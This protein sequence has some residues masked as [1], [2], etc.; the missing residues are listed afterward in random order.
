MQSG[1]TLE[2]IILGGWDG[3]PSMN[4][5]SCKI[6]M[7]RPLLGTNEKE[8]IETVSEDHK[9]T[10][11]IDS[12]SAERGHWFTANIFLTSSFLYRWTIRIFC[13][14]REAK[15]FWFLPFSKSRYGE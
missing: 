2:H 15:P 7:A 1:K 10:W 12:I 11:Q 9:E 6:S 4:S 3:N 13:D 14:D 8:I 5:I